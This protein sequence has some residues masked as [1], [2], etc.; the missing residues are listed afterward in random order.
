MP[1]DELTPGYVLQ[2][3]HMITILP[4]GEMPSVEAA[5]VARGPAVGGVPVLD[6]RGDASGYQG[7]WAEL[8]TQFRY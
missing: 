4:S 5:G 6:A 3:G 7:E 2:N 1:N 8:V